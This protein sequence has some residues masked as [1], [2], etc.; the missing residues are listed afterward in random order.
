MCG[1]FAIYSSFQAIK[2]YANLLNDIDERGAN[3]NIAPGQEIS[4]IINK[5]QQKNLKSYK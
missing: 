5:N 2:D 3:Y 4:I 1:R